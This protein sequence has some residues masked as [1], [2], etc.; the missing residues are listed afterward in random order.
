MKR[1]MFLI[2]ALTI[3]GL[4][5]YAEGETP[6]AEGKAD[7]GK[8]KVSGCCSM[9]KDQAPASAEADA[10]KAKVSGCCSMKKDQAPASAE[11]DV[12][13]HKS[14]GYCGMDRGQYAFSRM[15]IVYEDGSEKG[16]CCIHCAAVEFSINLDKIQKCVQV[17]DYNTK[18]LIDA[19]KAFWVIGG[20]KAGVMS[21]RAKWAFEGKP[22]AEEFVKNYGGALATYEEAMKA[23]YEDMYGDTRMIREKRKMRK[24]KEAK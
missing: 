1:T 24:M 12:G 10:G 4:H 11:A 13:K 3:A 16:V 23:T 21:K 6:A 2:A 20:S 19:E 7:A 15:L 22:E 18:K 14:C 17:G 5:V 9:K 8:A